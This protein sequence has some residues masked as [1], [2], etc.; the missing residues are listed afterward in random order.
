MSKPTAP[1]CGHCRDC[2]HARKRD[3]VVYPRFTCGREEGPVFNCAVDDE[4][5]CVLFE[6]RPPPVR[7][8][9]DHVV[10]KCDGCVPTDINQALVT[11]RLEL[12]PVDGYTHAAV[13]CGCAWLVR[14]EETP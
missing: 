12:I 7:K 13:G 5:G 6:R 14:I 3:G 10:L 8:I 4:F 9:T 11:R 1:T 2:Q